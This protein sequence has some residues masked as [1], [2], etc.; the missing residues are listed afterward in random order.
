MPL[1]LQE[2]FE[3][4]GYKKGGLPESERCSRECFAVP[5]YPELTGEEKEYIA[6]KIRKFFG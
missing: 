5:V 6:D 3:F 4:L 2:C 1:H